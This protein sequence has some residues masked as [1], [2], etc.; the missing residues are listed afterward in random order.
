VIERLTIYNP[1]KTEI[2]DHV[3]NERLNDRLEQTFMEMMVETNL[4]EKAVGINHKVALPPRGM[5]SAEQG[6]SGVSLSEIVSYSIVDDQERLGGLRLLEWIRAYCALQQLAR[7]RESES[8]SL[9]F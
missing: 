1:P 7:D 6:H 8:G 4:Q 3:A 5:I 9:F 2:F